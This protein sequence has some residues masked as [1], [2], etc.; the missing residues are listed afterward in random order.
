M[1]RKAKKDIAQQ[2][3]Q[4]FGI[5]RTPRI[6]TK[7][8]KETHLQAGI[9]GINQLF[10]HHKQL[11]LFTD[12]RVDEF[13]HKTGVPLTGDKPNEFGVAFN[14]YEQR[15]FFAILKGLTETNYEGHHKIEKKE[16][17]K[18]ASYD[19]T[20]QS[21][22]NVSKEI[23]ANIKDVPVL[24]I[25]QSQLLS[26]CDFTG[27]RSDKE[28]LLLALDK[29]ATKQFFFQ[30]KRLASDKNGKP[31]LDGEGR[32]KM[33]LVEEVSTVLRVLVIRDEK[34]NAIKGYQVQPSAAL[35]DQVNK[36]Y[37]GNYFLIIPRD[38]MAEVSKTVGKKVSTYTYNFLLWLRLKYELIRRHNKSH[39]NKQP[40]IL[41]HTWDEIAQALKMPETVYKRQKKRGH[42]IITDAYTVAIKLGYLTEVKNEGATDRLYLNESNFPRP[43]TQTI[44]S[45]GT[46][47]SGKK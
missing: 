5:S 18:N 38:W 44:E 33:E 7:T 47:P 37:G 28:S 24:N 42:K 11:N 2:I 29:L 25:T 16:Y 34:T 32:Y 36:S 23:Y 40:Y 12:N 10:S 41:R 20:R 19:L 43:G 8:Q 9:H 3:E 45:L 1:G 39:K 27:K 6:N 17:L 21:A 13:S 14:Q 35:I 46:G 15:V 4:D 26:L 30:W 31:I 22:Q